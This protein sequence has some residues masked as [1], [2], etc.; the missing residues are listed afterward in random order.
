MPVFLRTCPSINNII[1]S[2]EVIFQ[3]F[4][5]PC[6]KLV[7]QWKYIQSQLFEAGCISPLDYFPGDPRLLTEKG[8]PCPFIQWPKTAGGLSLNGMM[9]AFENPNNEKYVVVV[10]VVVMSCRLNRLTVLQLCCPKHLLLPS[11]PELINLCVNFY[12]FITPALLLYRWKTWERKVWSR[13]LRI[14]TLSFPSIVIIIRCHYHSQPWLWCHM[15][16]SNIIIKLKILLIGLLWWGQFWSVRK[17]LHLFHLW[18]LN[19]GRTELCLRVFPTIP[20]SQKSCRSLNTS[21]QP[22]CSM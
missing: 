1:L 17:T 3:I 2:S 16:F 15:L 21:S 10:V 19:S 8:M 14:S 6:L 13:S 18:E 4:K 9:T 7:W 20:F 22:N 5:F 12:A 11:C